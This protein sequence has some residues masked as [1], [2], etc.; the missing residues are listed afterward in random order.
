MIFASDLGVVREHC[1]QHTPLGVIG[2][3]MRRAGAEAT[4]LVQR[5]A[6]AVIQDRELVHVDV[7]PLLVFTRQLRP[8]AQANDRDTHKAND[9]ASSLRALHVDP[10]TARALTG[11]PA[12][13]PRS[14]PQTGRALGCHRPTAG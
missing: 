11:T 1:R 6:A 5:H 2:S 12:G 13:N 14:P 9:N 3:H 4:R 7:H 10:P 8:R